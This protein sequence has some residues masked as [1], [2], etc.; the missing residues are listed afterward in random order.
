MLNH[1]PRGTEPS[2]FEWPYPYLICAS[3][4]RQRRALDRPCRVM[5]DHAGQG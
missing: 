3:L 4:L 1:G 5:G 2:F